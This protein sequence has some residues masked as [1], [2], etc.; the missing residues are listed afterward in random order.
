MTNKNEI[1]IKFNSEKYGA[2]KVIFDLNEERIL[3]CAKDVARIFGFGDPSRSVRDNCS[4]LIKKVHETDGGYQ[5]MNFIT[6]GDV[7]KL[8]NRSRIKDK[9]SALHFMTSSVFDD[10]ESANFSNRD[11]DDSDY[12]D[13][14]D[15]VVCELE[16]CYFCEMKDRC[17]PDGD[18]PETDYE[19]T[20]NPDFMNLINSEPGVGGMSKEVREI[21]GKESINDFSNFLDAVTTIEDMIEKVCNNPGILLKAYIA[22]C[23]FLRSQEVDYD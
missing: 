19:D 15:E 7:F 11:F 2:L 21:L 14:D 13:C 22:V 12:D 3:Y 10:F 5:V 16:D 20:H 18:Y 8:Y 1:R 6:V 9:R 23:D 17:Y 4:N